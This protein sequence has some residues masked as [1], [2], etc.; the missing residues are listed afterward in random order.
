MKVF[1][2]S[3]PNEVFD[4]AESARLADLRSFDLYFDENYQFFFNKDFQDILY[5]SSNYQNEQAHSQIF[6]QH[7]KF[8][9]QSIAFRFGS[10]SKVVEVGCGKGY[11]FRLLSE[12][13]FS[14]IQGYDSAYEGS[15]PRVFKRY[16]T[17][18][19]RPLGAEVLVL[20]HVLEHINNPLQFLN[21]LAEINEKPFSFVIEV[22]ATEWI[23]ANS[24]FWD[25]TY[26]HVNYF[27]EDSFEK[28][29]SRC[30]IERVFNSQYLLVFGESESLRK[31]VGYSIS[32]SSLFEDLFK[33][34]FS[35]NLFEY[36]S[37]NQ[38]VRFWLWGG[39]TKG[40][41]I[42][43]HL[44]NANGGHKYSLQGIIDINPSKQNR[45]VSGSGIKII[46]PQSFFRSV[47][48]NDVVI[49]VNPNYELEVRDTI[50]QGTNKTVQIL[51]LSV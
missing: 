45:F 9:A 36:L 35:T 11:F 26:E 27:T 23:I 19:D 44:L 20:R 14:K 46:S 47:E 34:A 39:A 5:T 15:D 33:N 18:R 12:M 17:E 2:P 48:N 22:P 16:L 42:S 4:S 38:D 13:N 43:H 8:V 25:F 29:F 7:L 6:L 21:Q 41:L 37:I 24:A 49:V 1:L 32:K 30:Q 31:P 50:G 28:M 40:V 10:A 3:L 51:S